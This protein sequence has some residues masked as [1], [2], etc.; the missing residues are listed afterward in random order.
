MNEGRKGDGSMSEIKTPAKIRKLQQVLQR[1]AKANTKWRAWS[2]YADLLRE[3]VLAHAAAKVIANKGAAGIDGLTVEDIRSPES[4]TRFLSDLREELSSKEYKP[5]PVLCVRIPKKDGKTRALG[6]PTVK[7]RVVQTALVLL[8]EPIFEADMHPQS[9]GYRKGKDAHQAM[10]SI[11][12]ALYSGR[13]EVIDAD[14]SGYFDN[15]DHTMLMK[16]VKSRV[17]DGSILKLIK[18]FLKAPV[19]ENGTGRKNDKGTPQGGVLSPLLA[20][21]YLNGLD[22]QVNGKAGE[23]AKMIRYADDLVI[24]CHHGKGADLLERLDRY[25]EAKGLSLNRKKTRRVDFAKEGFS[26][27]GFQLYWRTSLKRRKRYVHV[28]PSRDSQKALRDKV[29]QEL[30][31]WTTWKSSTAAVARVNRIA[32]G[33]GNY[34]HYRSSSRAFAQSNDWLRARYRHW[35]WKKHKRKHSYYGFFT[36]AKLHGTYKLHQLPMTANHPPLW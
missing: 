14:I 24:L 32:R 15:I 2:L 26:F 11:C 10:D 34:F 20:N 12:R 28:E 29:R 13:H 16:L 22:H 21:L 33:W 5:S 30:N 19:V 31:H 23:G 25:L 7:D 4:R 8:L 18:A 3:D 27:L 6:I 1:N 17:S 36:N 9:Y 35:L